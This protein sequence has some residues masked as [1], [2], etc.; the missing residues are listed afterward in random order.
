MKMFIFDRYEKRGGENLKYPSINIYLTLTYRSLQKLFPFLT[1]ITL[2]ENMAFPF[3]HAHLPCSEAHSP[4]C[5]FCVAS[6]FSSLLC[7]LHMINSC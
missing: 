3:I 7:F 2:G 4:T 5:L 1:T 6:S